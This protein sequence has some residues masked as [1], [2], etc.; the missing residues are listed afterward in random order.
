MSEVRGLGKTLLDSLLYQNGNSRL[1]IIN[2]N[3]TKGPHGDRVETQG[4]TVEYSGHFIT[5]VGIDRVSVLYSPLVE[6]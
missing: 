5:L 4:L 1:S 6:G 2:L 3:E